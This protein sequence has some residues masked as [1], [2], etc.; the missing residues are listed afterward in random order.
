MIAS[1]LS[2]S[3]CSLVSTLDCQSRGRGF[4]SRR[5]R[6]FNADT[7][8]RAG[9]Q[10]PPRRAGPRTY[11]LVRLLPVSTRRRVPTR[12]PARSACERR[13]GRSVLDVKTRSLYNNAR[14][15]PERS[16]GPGGRAHGGAA[17]ASGYPDFACGARGDPHRARPTRDRSRVG[18][19]TQRDH[20]EHLSRASGPSWPPA[21]AT[22]PQEPC[23]RSPRD[24]ATAAAAALVILLDTAPVVA[25]CDPRDALNRR[26]LR[27]L[28]RLGREQFV[29]CAPVV[30]EACFL[31]PYRAQRG[32]LRRFLGE[33]LVAAYRSDDESQLWLEVLDWLIHYGEHDPDW[34]DGYLAVVSGRERG[35]RVWT[36]DRE[37]RTTWRRP[38]GTRVPLAVN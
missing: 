9:P 38:D 34:A 29:L 28:D 1:G 16:P 3:W 36:Y 21:R 30:T 7:V 32:R 35:S 2:G 31:L 18:Q 22:G 5:A 6:H 19:T 4:K 37:F 14:E 11:K 13:R 8:A 27:D 17:A 33:F 10:G 15:A 26:A 23:G 12:A 24:P 25:L 20:D